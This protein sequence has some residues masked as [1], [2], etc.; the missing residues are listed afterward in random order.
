MAHFLSRGESL[1]IL[2]KNY[3]GKLGYITKDS[4]F[5][6]PITYYYNEIENCIMAFSTEGHKLIGMRLNTKVC[7]YV[8]EIDTVKK[9]RTILIHGSFDEVDRIDQ[10]FYLKQVG[11][12]INMLL[13]HKKQRDT[14]SMDEFS[15]V[16][17]SKTEPILYRIEIWDTTGRFM[18]NQF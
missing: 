2:K 17:Y 4:P 7:L 12:G 5:I 10:E 11:D 18:E 13:N 16:N 9:W 14:K 8:E 6:V 3:L 1:D 15:N